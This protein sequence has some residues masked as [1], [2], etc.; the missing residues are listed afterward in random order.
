MIGKNWF[1]RAALIF[2]VLCAFAASAPA[3]RNNRNGSPLDCNDDWSGNRLFTHCEMKE[4]T[5]PATKGTLAVDA[6]EN[7][8]IRIKGWDRSDVLVRARIHS[9]A[10]TQSEA[11]ALATQVSVETANAKIYAGGPKHR[12]DYYWDV[13]Y[14][15]FVPRQ[16]DLSLETYNGGIGISDV[17]GRIEF[18]AVNGGIH[19]Q[20]LGGRVHGSTTNGGLHIELDGDRWDGEELDV[21]TTNGGIQMSV[22]ENYS[23][24]L[25][26]GTVNGSL[27][28]GFPVTM[29]GRITKEVNVVLGNGG[30]TVRALTTNGGVKINRKT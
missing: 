18:T 17:R 25:E 16:S 28:V 1:T 2:V 26:T 24:R 22:P 7:G 13:S 3:Q 29:Q 5:L 12:Q 9:A 19:L 21:E 14:E 30:A 27:N 11:D 8:G 23:A 6:R 4:Q 20:G 15:I 10:P